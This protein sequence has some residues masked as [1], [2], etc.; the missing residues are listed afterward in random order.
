MA[1]GEEE[2]FPDLRGHKSITLSRSGG[3]AREANPL[4]PAMMGK[5]IWL[6]P[7]DVHYDC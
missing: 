3:C 5:G 2:G 7:V 1:P 6:D 4:L